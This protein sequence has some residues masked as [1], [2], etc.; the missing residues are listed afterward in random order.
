MLNFRTPITPDLVVQP[1]ERLRIERSL[2]WCGTDD[3]IF[4]IPFLGFYA[5]EHPNMPVLNIQSGCTI[6]LGDMLEMPGIRPAGGCFHEIRQG[7]PEFD[8]LGV[9]G[10]TP[11][12]VSDLVAGPDDC[13]VLVRSDSAGGMVRVPHRIGTTQS[14]FFYKM[15]DAYRYLRLVLPVE[16]F[17]AFVD[18]RK[19]VP[20]ETSCFYESNRALV[21]LGVGFFHFGDGYYS[22]NGISF[23]H[24]ENFMKSKEFFRVSNPFVVTMTDFADET[25]DGS[26]CDSRDF[27]LDD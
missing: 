4:I 2:Y 6:T 19:Y 5:D 26:A 1:S 20:S 16:E 27:E 9:D 23:L 10:K 8:A 25:Y 18:L 7:G 11:I 17:E 13:G 15:P 21:A 24:L 12:S 14:V 3:T 22:N